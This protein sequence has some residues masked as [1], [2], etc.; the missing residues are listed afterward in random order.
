MPFRNLAYLLAAALGTLTLAGCST[1]PG[2]TGLAGSWTTQDSFEHRYRGVDSLMHTFRYTNLYP[3]KVTTVDDT[4]LSFQVTGGV[5]V[6]FDS[7]AGA[8]PQRDTVYD[9]DLSGTIRIR[10]DTAL[11]Q[12]LGKLPLSGDGSPMV[13]HRVFPDPECALEVGSSI[14]IPPAP[15][16]I[17]DH[18]W[19]Q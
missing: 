11:V 13:S 15:V 4:S 10:G 7:V 2:S 6:Q 14:L 18:H 12:Y 9:V 16:C 1:E 8:S 5:Q 3:I 19:K 17:E